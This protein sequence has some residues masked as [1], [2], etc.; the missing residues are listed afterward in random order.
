MHLLHLH[1]KLLVLWAQF[2]SIRHVKHWLYIPTTKIEHR[3]KLNSVRKRKNKADLLL[4][5][6]VVHCQVLLHHHILRNELR[7]GCHLLLLLLLLH[8][9]LLLLL[10]LLLGRHS[11]VRHGTPAGIHRLHLHAPRLLR[12]ASRRDRSTGGVRG[13]GRL[14]LLVRAGGR[15]HRSALHKMRLARVRINHLHPLLLR[16]R[17]DLLLLQR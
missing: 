1:H 7:L 12:P 6:L 2:H 8:E 11:L 3:N 9:I 5:C 16:L 10:L 13:I 4:L 17:W 15:A 14:L